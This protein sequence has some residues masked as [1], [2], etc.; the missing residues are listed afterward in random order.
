M[1]YD[2]A[3]IFINGESFLASG[4]D[5]TLMRQL[6]DQHRLG[7]AEVKRL[8]V[9]ARTLLTQWLDDGWLQPDGAEAV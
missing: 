4:R 6:A 3:H 5:A 2:N 1:L 9:A 8:S 7:A